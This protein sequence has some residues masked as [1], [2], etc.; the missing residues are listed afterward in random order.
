MNSYLL[1]SITIV[2]SLISGSAK[3]ADWTLITKDPSADVALSID[4]ES[5]ERISETVM[6]V[7]MKYEY[8]EPRKFDGKYIKELLVCN[9]Y[10]CG[11]DTYRI[12]WSEGYF[13]DGTHQ[14]DTSERRG[15]L[16][17]DDA[18]YRY[19]CK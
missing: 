17:P 8:A 2:L 4:R 11:K 19:L 13:T 10:D 6:R 14:E 5:I 1:P 7:R 3:G 12:L 16:L 15:H 18:A 9:E